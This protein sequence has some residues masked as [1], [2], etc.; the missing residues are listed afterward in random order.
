MKKCTVLIYFTDLQ[1]NRY[2]YHAGDTFP[3]EGLEVS[4]ERIAELASSDN[5]RGKPL[6]SVDDIPEEPVSVPEEEP[7]D[8]KTDEKPSK[9][10]KGKKNA[11]KG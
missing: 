9:S 7:Q 4:D 10:T 1:D 6:I 2:A 5:K 8:T 3:R 11:K